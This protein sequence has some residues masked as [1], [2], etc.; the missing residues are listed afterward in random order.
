MSIVS[1]SIQILR[2]AAAFLLLPL[3]ASSCQWV[4]DDYDD[5]T[6]DISNATQ[7]INI[8]VSISA[9]SSPVTRAPLGGEYGDGAE[10]GNDNE[11]YVKDITLIFFKDAAG[12]NTTNTNTEVLYVKKYDVHEATLD[13]YYYPSDYYYHTHKDTEPKT[14]YYNQ[15]VVYTTGDQPLEENTLEAGETYQVLVVANADPNV[16]VHDKIVAVRDKVL[17]VTYDGTGT[18]TTNFVMTSE[19]DARITLKNPTVISNENKAIYYF[20]CIHMER[21]AARIDYWAEN[22][23][24]YKTSYATPGYEYAVKKPDGTDSEDRFVLTS[25]TPFNLNMGTTGNEYLF[26]RTNDTTNPY[27]AD[28]TITNWVTDPY[29]SG[30]NAASHPDWMVSTLTSVVS[31]LA[32]TYNITMA[33]QQ[34]NLL[35]IGNKDDIIIAYPRENT[36]RPNGDSPLYYYATGLAFEGY[37][38]RKGS[39]TGEHRVYYHFIRHQGEQNDAYDA[40]TSDNIDNAK[41]TYCPT[42]TAMNFGIVRNNIYRISV[43]QVTDG[44]LLQLR[45]AVHDWRNVEHPIIYI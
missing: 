7:Y 3:L 26:K 37:Y 17:N 24:G 27:L 40:W 44:G 13:D 45:I 10:M 16:T 38:Y 8:T 43:N 36:L 4:T 32:N 2:M 35:S 20:D 33:S 34:A 14:G 39:G 31:N 15:E 42:T 19:T 5:E 12:V 25:I 21:L 9:A 6:A 23:N 1:K 29:T 18:N 22:S 28:E 30:K 11:N 41:T